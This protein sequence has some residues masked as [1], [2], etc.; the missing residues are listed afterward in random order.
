MPKPGRPTAVVFQPNWA[1]SLCAIRS[2]GAAGIPVA[3]AY[4]HRLD[5]GRWSRY[6]KYRWRCPHGTSSEALLAWLI[7]NGQRAQG[8]VL[9]PGGDTTTWLFARHRAELSRYYRVNGPSIETVH[10]LLDKKRLG[11]LA[12]GVGIRTPATWTPSS[13]ADFEKLETAGKALWIKPR[14]QAAM[15]TFAK[16]K[17][18]APAHVEAAYRDYHAKLEYA[19]VVAEYAPDVTRPLVQEAIGGG[20]EP[21]YHL[22]G[23]VDTGGSLRAVRAARK[24]IHWQ[25]QGM[26]FE[27]APVDHAL[28]GQVEALCREAGYFGIFETEFLLDDGAPVLTDFNPRLY[29][30]ASFEVA[31]GMDMPGLAYASAL[32]DDDEVDRLC[33]LAAETPANAPRAWFDR[34]DFQVTARLTRGVPAETRASMRR[35]RHAHR[36]LR[37]L[38]PVYSWR[39]PLPGVARTAT[40]AIAVS[41]RGLRDW[42]PTAAAFRGRGRPRA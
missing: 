26:A 9:L 2:L 11:E 28:A 32:G 33:Q 34:L 20:S 39:D 23:F 15:R 27:D 19:A 14:I 30:G 3:A 12:A 10:A 17:P 35:W 22:T 42:P 25:G 16:G 18:L 37:T 31:R 41:Y 13:P 1:G 7:K 29:R 4:E 36:R 6:A 38:D 21:L 24:P 40:M 5:V 8:A